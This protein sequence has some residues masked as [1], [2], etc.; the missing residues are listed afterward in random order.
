M[1][2]CFLEG[3][4]RIYYRKNKFLK[5][6]TIVFVHG[7]S[8]S[9][10]AWLPYESK[11][12]N[13]F[14]VL[15]FDLRGHGKSFRPDRLSAHSITYFAS[16]LYRIIKKENIKKFIMVAHS[17]GNFI[18][19]D[20]INKHQKMLKALILI[21]ADASL[22]K[23]KRIQIIRPFFTISK[24]INY[25]P[26][27]KKKGKH[28]DYKKYIATG[29][30]NISRMFVDIKNTG[31]RTHIF[32]LYNAYSFN[33]NYLHKIKIPTL[34]I[35]GK[36]DTIFPIKAGI[37]LNKSIKNSKLI[38]FENANHI[39]VLNNFKELYEELNEFIKS[40]KDS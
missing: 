8:G 24:L 16:D 15:S 12:K 1:E 17:F 36:K 10:S 11:F 38:I 2:E 28:V 13:K 27:I 21:S 22:A 19:L 30:W 4:E 23:R 29:D 40:L 35:H 37:Q 18:A 5:R 14:N 31:L 9:S 3:K 20:F 6:H 39:I 34:I 26:Q 33:C 32:S 7:L 25:F